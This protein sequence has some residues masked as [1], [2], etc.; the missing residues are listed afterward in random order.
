MLKNETE[1]LATLGVTPL[2]GRKCW[3][4]RVLVHL[5]HVL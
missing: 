5:L 1:T 2:V 3:L 4:R